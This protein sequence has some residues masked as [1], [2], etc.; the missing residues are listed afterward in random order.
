VDWVTSKRISIAVI[1]AATGAAIVLAAVAA[2]GAIHLVHQLGSTNSH[3]A[4][5]KSSVGWA[6]IVVV[7]F[8]VAAMLPI[9]RWRQVVTVGLIL[10]DT[11][12]LFVLPE[13]SAPRQVRVD[14][15]PV[16]FL[17]RHLGLDR[18][19]TLGPIQPN[20][21]SYFGVRSLNADDVPLPSAFASFVNARIDQA[22]NPLIFN[23]T[24]PGRAPS[25]PT[26]LQELMRN[27]TGYRA[28]S[29]RYVLTPP[30]PTLPT[31]TGTFTL[32]DRTPTTWIYRLSGSAPYYTSTVAGC[33]LRDEDASSARTDCAQPMTLVRRE[34]FMPGWTA[35]ID[36]RSV[37]V[38]PYYGI[39]QRVSIP[40][41]Q[42]RITFDYTPPFIGWGLAGMATGLIC[43]LL[44]TLPRLPRARFSRPTVASE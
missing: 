43:L 16:A 31:T 13:L 27:L 2:V 22:V 40:A 30:S 9:A 34:T 18:F 36:G 25:A 19:S 37:A 20:Y 38:R 23:G 26:P 3:G 5:S 12:A 24:P 39:F 44:P 28:A 1:V 41:G 6:V 35:E 7:G 14:T 42:H 29:V 11:V 17:Q 21:G 8:G 32:V 4:Y 33:R 10:V 15:A